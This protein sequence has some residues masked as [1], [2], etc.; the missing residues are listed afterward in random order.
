MPDDRTEFRIALLIILIVGFIL[1][2]P[3]IIAVFVY[4][5]PCF[6]KNYQKNLAKNIPLFIIEIYYI[7]YL[8][9]NWLGISIGIIKKKRGFV[10]R[11]LLYGNFFSIISCIIIIYFLFLEENLDFIGFFGFYCFIMIC[12]FIGQMI[13][14]FIKKHYPYNIPFPKGSVFKGFL[15]TKIVKFLH[16]N[17]KNKSILLGDYILEEKDSNKRPEYYK[18]KFICPFCELYVT[19]EWQPDVL[20]NTRKRSDEIFTISRCTDCKKMILWSENTRE[21]IYPKIILINKPNEALDNDIKDLYIEASR[22]YK[23]SPKGAGALLRLSLERLLKKLKIPGDN[24]N[25]QIK[26]LIDG[27]V[28][29]NIKKACDIVRVYGNYAVHAGEIDLNDNL[30]IVE[31]LFWLINRIAYIKITEK[32][33]IDSLYSKLPKSKK[34]QINRRDHK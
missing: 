25:L 14:F 15:S 34:N 7:L 31:T 3:W 2:F 12:V 30:E 19:H 20:E 18:D 27:G 23:E 26:S 33:K 16:K 22:I 17:R 24:L 6:C 21:I 32:K 9:A 13:T 11:R 10:S 8:F 29:E 1:Y 5:L 4:V 28:D